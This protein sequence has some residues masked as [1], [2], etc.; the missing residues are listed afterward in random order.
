M[1]CIAKACYNNHFY[2]N[3]CCFRDITMEI[4]PYQEQIKD[5]DARGKELW[6]YL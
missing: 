1:V 2:F 4:A 3:R 5:L 6:G